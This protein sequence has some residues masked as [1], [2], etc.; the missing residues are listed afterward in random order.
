MLVASPYAIFRA[1][2]SLR[3]QPDPRPTA[4]TAQRRVIKTLAPI[5]PPASWATLIQGDL[6][7]PLPPA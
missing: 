7:D 4:A 2:H 6:F 5:K 1:D 3:I